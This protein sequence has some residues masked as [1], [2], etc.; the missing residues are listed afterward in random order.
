MKR[1]VQQ[2]LGEEASATMLDVQAQCV[3]DDA[4]SNKR[5]ELF[6]NV[7]EST[8]QVL[9]MKYKGQRIAWRLSRLIRLVGVAHF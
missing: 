2:F 8:L 1:Q 3:A 7:V 9:Q 6:T 4:D 5:V